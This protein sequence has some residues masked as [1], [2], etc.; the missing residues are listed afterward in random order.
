[1]ALN[2]KTGKLAGVA[3]LDHVNI[4]TNDIEACRRFYVDGLGFEEG[5]RP[6]LSLPGLWLYIGFS[7]VV[8]IIEIDEP[9]PKHSGAVG[10]ADFSIKDSGAVDHVAFRAHNF[11][12]FT[13]RLDANGIE[14]QDRELPGRDLHQLFCFDPHGVKVEF[15]FEGQDRP[16]KTLEKTHKEF[17]KSRAKDK[18]K[19]AKA[20]G[21]K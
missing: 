7:P 13:A 10:Q 6:A 5:F 2:M 19:S 16:W 4:L 15:N 14:W 11:E 9:L 12:Q 3:A 1:M 18:A 21:R 17:L 20:K 8:H